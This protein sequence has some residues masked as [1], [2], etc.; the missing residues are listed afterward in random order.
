MTRRLL[1][2]AALLS[3]TTA[4]A[5]VSPSRKPS[6]KPQ[7]AKPSIAAQ[8]AAIIKAKCVDCHS[9]AFAFDAT[10]PATLLAKKHI[11]AG[12]S[13]ASNAFIYMSGKEKPM[14]PKPKA[15]LTAAELAIVKQW[16]DEGAKPADAPAAPTTPKTGGAAASSVTKSAT[17]AGDPSATA[18]RALEIIKANCTGISAYR[19]TYTFTDRLKV[20]HDCSLAMLG[21]IPRKRGGRTVPE[22]KP[23]PSQPLPHRSP[24]A[25]R[26]CQKPR[27]TCPRTTCSRPQPGEGPHGRPGCA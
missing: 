20:D 1:T 18:T 6:V 15:P 23:R 26:C 14:P 17:P 9:G 25:P 16:I 4:I 3:A 22:G 2:V 27:P 12:K 5:V 10:K 13:A 8:A 11:V 7:A 24:P 19:K 21:K